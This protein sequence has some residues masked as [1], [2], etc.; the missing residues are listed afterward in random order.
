MVFT[1]KN[2]GKV[3]AKEA[4]QVYVAPQNPSVM[5][6]A[7]ELKGFGKQLIAKG[8]SVEFRIPLGVNDFAYYDVA[9]HDWKVD[10]GAY[11]I[12]VGSSS[13]DIKLTLDY[14]VR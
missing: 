13:A 9:S 2:T 11:K 7:Y 1:V 14:T 4:V 5:R 6:P 12:Q 10:A 8:K 3:D